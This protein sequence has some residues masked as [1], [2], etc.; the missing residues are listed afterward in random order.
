[1]IPILTV[2]VTE[3]STFKTYTLSKESSLIIWNS[4]LSRALSIAYES[5]F[6]VGPFSW[7]SDSGFETVDH[8]DITSYNERDLAS[9]L[10]FIIAS[11]GF[12]GIAAY[13]YIL[14]VLCN[15]K[16]QDQIDERL[17]IVLITQLT[18]HEVRWSGLLLTPFLGYFLCLVAWREAQRYLRIGNIYKMP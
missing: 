6:G 1:L 18:V 7:I 13:I 5:P 14:W 15:F 16:E 9:S 17:S 4:T 2:L 11:Y 10:A 12:I 8:A 3:S